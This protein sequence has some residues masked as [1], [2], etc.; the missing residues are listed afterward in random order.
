MQALRQYFYQFDDL[1]AHIENVLIIV[2]H[3]VIALLI[4]MAVFFRYALNDPI[5]WGEELVVGLFTWMIFLGSAAAIRNH[6]HIRID[7]MASVYRHARMRWLNGF[8]LILGI[9]ILAVMVYACFEQVLQEAAVD[10]P[11]LGLSKGWFLTSMPVGLTLMIV[12]CLRI[13]LQQ[14]AAPVF[15]GETEII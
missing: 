11:M 1:L 7:V 2:A 9:I 5:T 4:L 3:A 10:L 15:R 8:T 6:M 12:H 14:G 13:W